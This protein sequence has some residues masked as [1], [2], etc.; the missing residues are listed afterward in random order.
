MSRASDD[1]ASFILIIL[2][3]G[4][5]WAHKAFF[6]RAEHLLPVIWATMAG[7]V[8]LFTITKLGIRARKHRR[9]HNPT[10]QIIDIMTGLEFEKYVARL[11]KAQ[12]Y[13]HIK[14]T[15]QYD[16]GIDII[17]EKD[18][19]RWGVQ[20]KCYSNLVGADAVRQAVTAL[21]HYHCDRAMVITNSVFS[22][23]AVALADSNGCIL[24]DSAKLANGLLVNPYNA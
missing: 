1:H 3:A 8:C 10:M 19:V 15:E 17:A 7:L 18:G 9:L 24:V 20:V 22:R 4:T 5:I 23:S 16:L 12:C 11:L 21:R 14:L 6:V 2:A 13:S